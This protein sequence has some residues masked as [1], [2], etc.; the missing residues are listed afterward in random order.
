[1]AARPP[2][3]GRA[4]M[5]LWGRIMRSRGACKESIRGLSVRNGPLRI[6]CFAREKLSSSLDLWLRWFRSYKRDDLCLGLLA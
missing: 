3:E 2:W 1:M 4:V 5:R 6:A